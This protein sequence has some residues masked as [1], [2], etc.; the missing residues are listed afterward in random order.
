VACHKTDDDGKGHRGRFGDKCQSCH[1]EKDWKA[2]AFDHDRDTKYPLRGKH[3]R[4]KCS[5]CHTG[6]LYRDKT[7][8]VCF[9]CH[10]KDDKHKGQ[11]G[12]KCE[13]C[14]NERNWKET[15]FDHGL[16]RFPLLGRHV[17]IECKK[18][19]LSA[20]FKDAE[21]DCYACHKKD[22]THK[23]KLGPA[24]E[25]CHNARDWK[26]WN[27]DHNR[28]TKYR[29]DGKHKGLHCHACHRLPMDSRVQA[30][31]ACAGCHVDDDVHDGNF[32]RACER[33]H[34]TD[35]FK[36]LKAGVMRR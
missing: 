8:T 12:R 13:S 31:T 36:Q 34:V 33:C 15:R 14:H 26:Q 18:C 2:I 5:A 17:K 35:S 24:C 1:V 28:R 30:P 29:L 11:E 21:S 23:L 6:T 25:Q 10:E 32:G 16:T 19:H 7:P 3:A 27:F 4:T 9:S 22:D 20:A